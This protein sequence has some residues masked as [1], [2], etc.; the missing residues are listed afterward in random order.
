M[1]FFDNET[2]GRKP[3]NMTGALT[4]KLEDGEHPADHFLVV[5]DEDDV[6]TWNLV[7]KDI[8]GRYNLHLF[9][10]AWAA[11]THP[12]GFRGRKFKGERKVKAKAIKDLQNLY[13]K[14]GRKTPDE[15]LNRRYSAEADVSKIDGLFATFV[16]RIIEGEFRGTA[17]DVTIIGP[18]DPGMIVVQGEKEYVLSKNNRL[19]SVDGLRESVGSWSGIKVYDNHL[20]EEDFKARAGQRSVKDEW[21]GTLRDDHWNESAHSL[22]AVLKIV[23]LELASKLK[24]AHEEGVLGQIGLS[25]DTFPVFADQPTMHEGTEMPV[26]EGFQSIVSVDLVAEPAAGGRLNR[27]LAS[28]GSEASQ[29]EDDMTEEQIKALVQKILSES[30]SAQVAE[31][32]EQAVEGLAPAIQEAVRAA[33]ADAQNAQEQEDEDATPDN[34]E[35]DDSADT[36]DDV[37]ESAISGFEKRLAEFERKTK[38]D[39]DAMALRERLSRNDVTVLPDAAQTLIREQFEDQ[40]FD[41]PR[42]E[43]A[44]TRVRESMT[45]LDPTGRI[46]GAGTSREGNAQVTYDQ[47]DK[48]TMSLLG[49]MMWG[50][51]WSDLRGLESFLDGSKE[52]SVIADRMP[53]AYNAWI[54]AGRPKVDSLAS[55]RDLTLAILGGNPLDPRQSESI[56]TGTLTSIMKNTINLRL[57]ADYFV[58]EKWWEPI[59]NSETVNTIE[60]ATFVRAYGLSTLD[61]VAEGGAYTQKT[62]EDEEETASYFKRGNTVGITMEALLKDR[63]NMLR[64][65]PQKLAAAWYNTLSDMVSATFTTNTAAGPVLSDTGALFNATAVGTPGGHANLGTAALSG[66]AFDAARL[67]MNKHTDQPLGV[68]RRLMIEPEYLAIPI[69]LR[70]T[71]RQVFESQNLPGSGNNDINPYYQM[72]KPLVIPTWTDTNNWALIANKTQWPALWLLFLSGM[73]TPAI[74]TAGDESSGSMFTNDTLLYK[75]RQLAFRYSSTYDCAPIADWRPLYKA[76]VS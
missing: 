69:D 35:Q 16:P 62:M 65:I 46:E 73:Q 68:G 67:A 29:K 2:E 49:K 14:L 64:Q 50:T 7:V 17:W 19:Y 36:E 74:F 12:N 39:A 72:V 5:L 21:V 1:P 32:V 61:E 37:T 57:A 63:L 70:S 66:A 47:T 9:G 25:I 76:N 31:A 6:M 22:D 42:L 8:N 23:D 20:S 60:D 52:N 55:T 45:E 28:V 10:A 53:E 54:K 58:M 18:G 24:T 30:I 3:K 27:I 33:V 40:S 51:R 44:I 59:A 71:A 13:H 43:T 11:L 4:K 38:A 41:L 26:I 48:W 75:I 56:T 15:R 34:T